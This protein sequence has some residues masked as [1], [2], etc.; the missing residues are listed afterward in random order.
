MASERSTLRA[1]LLT[2][3]LRVVGDSLGNETAITVTGLKPSHF[4]NICVVAVGPNNFSAASKV[5]RLRTY[6][7]GG[8]PELGNSRQPSGFT[9][10]GPTRS[11]FGSIGSGLDSRRSPVPAIEA[12]AAVLDGRLAPSR[13]STSSGP[14]QRRN[15]LNRRHSPSV[16]SADQPALPVHTYSGSGASLDE[17]N[18]KFES[19]RTEM[20]EVAAS[21]AK[22]EAEFVQQEAELKKD[23][24]KKRQLVKEKDEQTTLLKTQSRTTGEQM[25]A[26]LKEL[27]SKKKQLDD[28][29]TKKSKIR[30]SIAKFET[31]IE[32]M[33]AERESFAAKKT[34]LERK[35]DCN[36][37]ELDEQN[38]ELQEKV[39]ELA[40]ELEEKGKQLQELK[41]A[42]QKLPGAEAEQNNESDMQ[43]RQQWDLR[44]NE[45]HQQLVSETKRGVN[46]DQQ[47]RVLTEQLT[48]QQQSGLAQYHQPDS[49]I[50]TEFDAS[51][52]KQSK[53]LSHHSNTIPENHIPFHQSPGIDMSPQA[54]SN[55]SRHALAQVFFTDTAADG[56]NEPMSE[57]DL[58]AASGPM[59]PSA[60]T[61]IPAFLQLDDDNI[62][63]KL[64]PNVELPD[65]IAVDDEEPRSPSSSTRSPSVYAS[66]RE[67]QQHLPFPTFQDS[68]DGRH[69]TAEEP[70]AAS[71]GAGGRLT[72]FFS[73]LHRS[74][75]AGSSADAGPAFGSLKTGQS[76]SFPRGIEEADLN[77]RKGSWGF[78]INRNSTGLDGQSATAR[79][80]AR[81]F[82]NASGDSGANGGSESPRPA[83][84]TS[85]DLP[86]PSTDSSSIW[87]PI[88]NRGPWS[89]SNDN[90]W[91]SRSGSRRPSLQ[92]GANNMTT[93]LAN[94]DDDILDD[95]EL[96]NPQTSAS[97][98][99]VIGSR[100]P[101][102]AQPMQ[103]ALNPTAPTF[104]GNV[105]NMFRKDK[106]RDKDSG[107][108]D[109][110]TASETPKSKSKDK[111]KDKGKDKAKDVATPSIEIPASNLDDSPVDSRMSR[112]TFSV[113]TQTSVSESHDSLPLDT[114]I[115]NTPS[116]AAPA[117][118]NLGP[119]ENKVRK[120]FRK[121]S[122]SK[123]SLSSRLGKD[124]SL[125]KKGPGSSANSDKNFSAEHRSSIGDIDDLGED[126]IPLGRSYD[127]TTSS[128][129]LGPART[130]D[131]KESRMS[132]WR[133]SIKKKGKDTPSK[134]K[135][136]LDLDRAPDED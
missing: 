69:I 99:G 50:G 65:S 2:D 121:G 135:E 16:A 98:V 100:P 75:P 97:Q 95:A 130:K 19:I 92:G 4:Y 78:N 10:N 115:S 93:T 9:D 33:R 132:N 43:L 94:A 53:R 125:F 30:D 38:S 35:R 107:G 13:E 120:L 88:G 89:P 68:P 55:L 40:A 87:G 66:P 71:L 129:S 45:L 52:T 3:F 112:D 26:A 15:T 86:R 72:S 34:E 49:V 60:H 90:R 136:S 91:A 47:L 39:E 58:I 21:F 62:D 67:S 18:R 63:A 101:A 134:E 36:V 57:A 29:E 73:S 104:M 80:I 122:S 82:G 118:S 48:I 119:Q 116:D 56:T 127:S 24:E 84:V 37:S 109:N 31:E 12:A 103:L 126:S 23:K 61:L 14:G 124:S 11:T 96:L 42:R 113:H 85:T 77:R 83:S 76:Q 106:D 64:E 1:R 17:L 131:S 70:P 105:S 111:G 114:T 54:P 51:S 133:F 74:K 28:K 20:D 25:R 5:I 41:V 6:N 102:R 128:P 32:R 123:F 22:E 44:R 59:S 27:N 8:K 46:Q 117:S 110:V 79:F 81:R 108:R 7:E